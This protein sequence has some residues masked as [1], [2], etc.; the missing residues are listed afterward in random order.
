MI[1]AALFSILFFCTAASALTKQEVERDASALLRA[2]KPEIEALAKTLKGSPRA[3]LENFARVKESLDDCF[4]HGE[5]SR[6]LRN[7]LFSGAMSDP[8]LSKA[9]GQN[10]L[11]RI[12]F[13]LSKLASATDFSSMKKVIQERAMA[14]SAKAIFDYRSEYEGAKP[15][16]DLMDSMAI[17]RLTNEVCRGCDYAQKEQFKKA[18][19]EQAQAKR[20]EQAGEKLYSTKELVRFQNDAIDGFNARIESMEA[21]KNAQ[22]EDE[23]KKAYDGYLE[24]YQAFTSTHAGALFMTDSVRGVV[25]KV[26][27]PEDASKTFYLAG[28]IKFPR[29]KSLTLNTKCTGLNCGPRSNTL[30]AGLQEIEAKVGDFMKNVINANSFKDLLKVDP[31]LAGQL[32][33]INPS[34]VKDICTAAQSVIDEDQATKALNENIDQAIT[35]LDYASMG[36]MLIGGGG[37][38]LKAGLTLAKVVVAREGLKAGAR[39]AGGEIISGLGYSSSTKGVIAKS[40]NYAAHAGAASEAAHALSDGN[41]LAQI[42]GYSDV[43]LASRMAGATSEVDIKRLN[44]LEAQ[45]ANA[46][47]NLGGASLQNSLP[48]AHGLMKI[49]SSDFMKSL[50]GVNPTRADITKAEGMLAKVA[51]GLTDAEKKVIQNAKE[52]QEFTSEQLSLLLAAASHQDNGVAKLVRTLKYGDKATLEKLKAAAS[53]GNTCTI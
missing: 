16:P 12:A 24:A 25:G 20:N 51:G 43:L 49:R 9:F 53:R 47:S 17:N 44:E 2:S 37:I 34:L 41:K 32:L 31:A 39:A 40:T 13:D 28:Q 26:I 30:K 6:G 36:L 38:V 45:W 19:I 21:A 3:K 7:S 48:L 29:H 11:Q 33:V 23:F 15:L 10:N 52:A 18:Y 46:L 42:Q 1:K 14:T 5:D 22:N 27:T 4:S 8:C 50:S 35:Y